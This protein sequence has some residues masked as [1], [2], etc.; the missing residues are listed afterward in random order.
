MNYFENENAKLPEESRVLLT[1]VGDSAVL[2]GKFKISQSIDIDCEVKGKLNVDGKLTI[3]KNGLVS[4]DVKTID[5]E[6]I[7]TYEGN[8]EASGAVEIKETGIANGNMKTDSL[9]I[10]KGGIF[11]G[12]VTRMSEEE[13]KSKKKGKASK[14]KKGDNTASEDDDEYP[15]DDGDSELVSEYE[16]RNQENE[17]GLSL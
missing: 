3:Q 17:E 11:S 5:A 6:I 16:N 12:N 14:I 2:D 1:I 8:M 7:G 4:A 10:N 15:A 9:I 13:E